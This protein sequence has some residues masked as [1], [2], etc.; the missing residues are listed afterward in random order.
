MD[1]IEKKEKDRKRRDIYYTVNR[2]HR[3]FFDRVTHR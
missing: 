2:K 1:N 3:K